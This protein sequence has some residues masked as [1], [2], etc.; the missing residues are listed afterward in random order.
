MKKIEASLIKKAFED[1]LASLLSLVLELS[2]YSGHLDF[3]WSTLE[4]DQERKIR[5]DEAKIKKG[6]A[7]SSNY[8]KIFSRY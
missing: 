3:S 1:Q 7:T 2:H 5:Q 4:L 8:N 6:K